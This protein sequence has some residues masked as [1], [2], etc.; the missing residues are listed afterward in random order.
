MVCTGGSC[1]STLARLVSVFVVVQRDTHFLLA[2]DLQ[3]TSLAVN[4]SNRLKVKAVRHL[5]RLRQSLHRVPSLRHSP[6][7]KMPKEEVRGRKT[8]LPPNLPPSLPPSLPRSLLR[9]HE[10]SPLTMMTLRRRIR[11]R[12]MTGMRKQHMSQRRSKRIL[13]LSHAHQLPYHVG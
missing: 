2:H 5:P 3:R 8:S 4:L 7:R 9:K 6:R 11:M 13:L 10:K 12:T 1:T